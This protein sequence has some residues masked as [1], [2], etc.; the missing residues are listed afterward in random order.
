M[1][2]TTTKTIGSKQVEYYSY[3]TPREM[4]LISDFQ[5]KNPTEEVKANE[6]MLGKL[7]VSVDGN[8][9]NVLDTVLDTFS[10]QEYQ[11]LQESLA[12]LFDNKKKSDKALST[13][14]TNE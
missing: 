9:E 5:K 14:A 3:I 8:K 11:E 6:M 10:L 12:Q 4:H 2:P 7:I 1:R 13:T